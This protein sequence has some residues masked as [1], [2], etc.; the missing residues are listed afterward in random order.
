MPIDSPSAAVTSTAHTDLTIDAEGI[1]Q[2]TIARARSLTILSTPV[3]DDVT[4]TV[5]RLAGDDRVRVL[6]L[7]GGSDRAFVGGADIHE[8]SG[9]TAETAVRFISGLRGLCDAVRDFPAPTL[10]RLAGWCLG[11]GLELAL[12]CDLRVADRSARF[13]M[14]EVKVGM[15]SVI[16]AAMLP[17]LIGEARSN[18]LLLTGDTID[19]D[20]AARWGLV[21]PVCEVGELDAVVWRAARGLAELAPEVLRQQKRL[22]RSWGDQT[23]LK[24]IDESVQAFGAAY[25]TGV[26]QRITRQFLEAKRRG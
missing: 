16:H 25:A 17:R 4:A 19:A 26:P 3:I 13:G 2:L 18:W 12:A 21:H 24:S 14:P 5:R 23:L 7:R 22:N 1:A 11:G 9:L 10:A 8:M 20:E 15:P 6:I